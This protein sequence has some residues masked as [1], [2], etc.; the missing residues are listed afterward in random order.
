MSERYPIGREDFIRLMSHNPSEECEGL[1]ADLQRLNEEYESTEDPEERARI[2]RM[3]RAV[4]GRMQTLHCGPC[5][6]Q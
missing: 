4:L 3:I 6:P 2:L 5:H 1:C